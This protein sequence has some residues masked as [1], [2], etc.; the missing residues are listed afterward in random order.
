MAHDEISPACVNRRSKLRFWLTD[1][2][3]LVVI[4]GAMGGATLVVTRGEHDRAGA[5]T[6]GRVPSSAAHG[7]RWILALMLA[8]ASV[9]AAGAAAASCYRQMGCGVAVTVVVAPDYC[10]ATIETEAACFVGHPSC[11][12]Q[13]QPGCCER[14]FQGVL[15]SLDDGRA[16]TVTMHLPDGGSITKAVTVVDLTGGGCNGSD[17][18][19]V[20]VDPAELAFP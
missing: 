18:C 16:C 10:E 1:V 9:A 2:S 5:P 11:L 14:W 4:R 12:A 3:A 15:E 19:D 6:A 17:G 8:A 20:G 7:R 13:E